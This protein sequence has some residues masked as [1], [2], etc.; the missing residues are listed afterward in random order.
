MIENQLVATPLTSGLPRLHLGQKKWIVLLLLGG[1]VSPTP[2]KNHG[3]SNSWDD[4]KKSQLN[5]K[6]WKI[7]K[8]IQ[9]TNQTRSC[10]PSVVLLSLNTLIH[11]HD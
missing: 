9:T 11:T 6:S 5:G 3:V 10:Q 8:Q 7:I 2:L 4:E 1:L